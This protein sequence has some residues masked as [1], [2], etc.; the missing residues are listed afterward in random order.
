MRKLGFQIEQQLDEVEERA[1]KLENDKIHFLDEFSNVPATSE[2]LPDAAALA[3]YVAPLFLPA[4]MRVGYVFA[5]V[6]TAAAT[7]GYRC[8][9]YRAVR[10]I[11]NP[12]GNTAAVAGGGVF[13]IFGPQAVEWRLMALGPEYRAASGANRRYIWQLEKELVLR[14]PEIYGVA[15]MTDSTD[16]QWLGG[17]TELTRHTACLA[18]P[19]RSGI[20]DFP[21]TLGTVQGGGLAVPGF[22]LRS[23][24]AVTWMGF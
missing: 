2:V 3:I 9:I 23:A 5:G 19:V 22:V 24:R 13:A 18:T 4:P 1:R 20:S 11:R 16:G 6:L 15:F 17:T 7:V 14:P 10:P 8:A 12:R 21:D